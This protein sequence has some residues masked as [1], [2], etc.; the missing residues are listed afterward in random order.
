MRSPGGYLVST[1]PAG[2][3]EADTFTC[4]HCQKVVVVKPKTDPADAGGLC[5]V[6]GGL[7]CSRCVVCGSC[8]P[9][10]AQMAASEARAAAL[11]S[12]GYN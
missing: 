9:W 3:Q 5:N 6:C 8:S 4:G 10:E 7:V 12:Y 11:R 2:T 1:G